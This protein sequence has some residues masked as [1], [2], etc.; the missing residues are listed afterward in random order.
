LF[1]SKEILTMAN[2]KWKTSK[3]GAK[4][5]AAPAKG[6][7]KDQAGF[8]LQDDGSG[9]YTVLGVDAAGNSVDA[10]SL[11]TLDPP[12]VS[13]DTAVMTIDAPVGMTFGVHA[14]TPPP[15]PSA[16]VTATVTA[17]ANDA[18]VGPFSAVVT[19]TIKAGVVTG[20]VV[21]PTP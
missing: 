20:I 17:K 2:L 16:T 4:K 19:F 1:L 9:N 14:A 21:V 12:P 6:K 5:A 7:A 3:A 11:F 10:S 8:D 18:T 15:K 13:S